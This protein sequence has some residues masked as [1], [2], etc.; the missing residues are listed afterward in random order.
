MRL[1]NLA[2]RRAR[3]AIKR[4]WSH[5]FVLQLVE[6][7]LQ[8]KQFNYYLQQDKYFLTYFDICL[9]RL[10]YL[11]PDEASNSLSRYRELPDMSK[12]GDRVYRHYQPQL[13]QQHN[14]P[15]ASATKAYA[16]FLLK[17][18]LFNQYEIV[19]SALLPCYMIYNNLAK[20]KVS[21][22]AKDNAY[23]PFFSIHAGRDISESTDNMQQLFDACGQKVTRK[24]RDQM[25]A[26]FEQGCEH[27]L[28]FFDA[29]HRQNQ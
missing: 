4:I 26:V 12:P 15:M 3:P 2:W 21:L 20:A 22:V 9:Y 6:G 28:N 25:L 11:T 5:P 16:D 27:G 8:Q 19:L 13:I 24:Q 14:L 10:A 29:V 7:S 23:Y 18:C 17:I 1:S